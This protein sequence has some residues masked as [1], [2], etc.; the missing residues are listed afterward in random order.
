LVVLGAALAGCH[1]EEANLEPGFVPKTH[2]FEGAVDEKY[3]GV[4]ISTD[5]T[6]TLDMANDGALKIV[7][8]TPTPSGKAKN[9]V[10]GKW[11]ASDG[12]V[13]FQYG[14]EKKGITVLKYNAKLDGGTMKLKQ[15]GGRHETTYKRK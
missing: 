14:D 4:W 3:V 11:L 12:S 15:D 9:E 2:V 1:N 8:L 6:S 7:T 10:A 13:L 5:G